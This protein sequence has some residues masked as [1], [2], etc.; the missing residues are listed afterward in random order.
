MDQIRHSWSEGQ[1]T[2]SPLRANEEGSD[3]VVTAVRESDA[4]RTTAYGFV[5]ESEHALLRPFA[6]G[7]AMEVSFVCVLTEQFDQAGLMVWAD[8]ERWVKAGVE[9]A[10]GAP[11]L[12][13][14]VTNPYSDWS[15]SPVDSWLGHKVTIRVSRTSDA[16]TFRARRESQDWQL[17]RVCHWP[18]S[19][20]THGGPH[21]AA[22]TREG[23]SVRFTSW[24]T[25]DPDVSLHPE[26]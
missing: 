15:V 13:A 2:H 6:V 8:V 14:V 26:G 1:W 4:W 5:H 19:V 20:V 3:L 7:T 21:L 16:L 12:G 10:D 24:V 25:T 17:V 23:L 22:P 9:Y 18:D 11:Q